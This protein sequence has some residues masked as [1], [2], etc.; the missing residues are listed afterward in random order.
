VGSRNKRIDPRQQDVIIPAQNYAGKLSNISE[1]YG[2]ENGLEKWLNRSKIK[3]LVIAG[4]KPFNFIGQ[5]L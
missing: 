5:L 1:E 2:E 3:T 4:R